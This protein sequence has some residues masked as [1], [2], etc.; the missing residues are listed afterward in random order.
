MQSI[1]FWLLCESDNQLLL[2]GTDEGRIGKFSGVS[3]AFPVQFCFSFKSP[4]V[5]HGGSQHRCLSFSRKVVHGGRD[6]VDG[7]DDYRRSVIVI[8]R[9]FFILFGGEDNSGN[10]GLLIVDEYGQVI[11]GIFSVAKTEILE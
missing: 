8:C 2:F 1:G 9:F 6:I 3:V 5:A 10:V 7:I 4:V 11:V